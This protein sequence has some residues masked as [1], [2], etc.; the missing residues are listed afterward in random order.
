MF[1]RAE[2]TDIAIPSAEGWWLE[3]LMM[4]PIHLHLRG[5]L[6]L[7]ETAEQLSKCLTSSRLPSQQDS[8]ET[9]KVAWLGQAIC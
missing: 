1:K 9:I 6:C 5:G 2:H 8:R 4:G 3:L 7:A